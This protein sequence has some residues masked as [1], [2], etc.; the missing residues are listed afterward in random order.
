MA[1]PTA[2]VLQLL[3]LLQSG[4][5]RTVAEL[6]SRLEVD[7]RTVRR[8]VDHLLDLDVP[9]E[10]VRGRYGGY[11]LAPGYRMP[12]LM[13]TDG[14]A[15]AVLL[16]LATSNQSG[17]VDGTGTDSETAAAKIRRVL[18]QRLAAR[19]DALLTSLTFTAA[20]G[21]TTPA[22]SAT[23]LPLADAVQHH[24]PVLIRYTTADGRRTDRP[25]HPYGLV[26]HSGRW[27]ATGLDPQA[28]EDRTFRLDRMASVR[29]LPGSFT[30]PPGLDPADRVLSSLAAT[31]YQHQVTLRIQAPPDVIRTRFPASV[32]TLT[33]LP[34]PPIAPESADPSAPWFRVQLR[35]ES[36]DWLPPLLASLDRPFTIDEPTE[37]RTRVTALATRL[38]ASARQP[39]SGSQA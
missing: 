2:R 18:P 9:V 24:R 1:R 15:L 29:T 34:P 23:L 16:S 21:R 20:P 37:L 3:E 4:G 33:E 35:A 26:V 11:R 6:A 36:L 31:P 30:P 19:L 12:P 27:Y 10:S 39:A 38:A 7:E 32:A 25:F 5:T 17:L 8:Y 28:G 13:L 22:D 14:E